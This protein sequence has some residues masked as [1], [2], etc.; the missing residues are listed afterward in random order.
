MPTTEWMNR[1]ET[2]KDKLSC[3]TD[4]A[5]SFNYRLLDEFMREWQQRK[6]ELQAGQITKE[7]YQ[8]WKLN[9]PQTSDG[10][11]KFQ[12]KKKWRKE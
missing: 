4:M 1:Y 5:V 11:G 8:E 6:K 2:I 12:S 7:E 10:C 9:W 3:K